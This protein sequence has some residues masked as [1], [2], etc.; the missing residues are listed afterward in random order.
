MK[1]CICRNISDQTF[2]DH[3][4]REGEAVHCAESALIRCCGA[5]TGCGQCLDMADEIADAHNRRVETVRGLRS[6]LP[7]S[8][9]VAESR[10]TV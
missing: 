4:A 3:L 10:E 6:A 8:A 7:V 2:A 9:P 1:L 5:P